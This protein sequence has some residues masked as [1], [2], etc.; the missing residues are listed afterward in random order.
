MARQALKSPKEA[1][2]V[3]KHSFPSI[4]QQ[5]SSPPANWNQSGPCTPISPTHRV[6][7]KGLLF[8]T[9]RSCGVGAATALRNRW[10]RSAHRRLPHRLWNDRFVY[11][12]V[13]N[14]ARR[15]KARRVTGTC[16][17]SPR[18]K[19][20]YRCGNR[21][22]QVRTAALWPRQPAS[23]DPDKPPLLSPSAGRGGPGRPPRGRGRRAGAGR[24]R[25][26]GRGRDRDRPPQAS[27][28]ESR[29]RC[30][31]PPRR[32]GGTGAGRGGPQLPSAPGR[33]RC[34]F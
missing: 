16:G 27:P 2:S 26:R 29:A 24:G 18:C 1:A 9:S 30:P 21:G 25:G 7:L 17:L 3:Y 15:R 22:R 12:H 5:L 20:C 19:S 4:M 32:P 11:S 33:R 13:L 8:G 23:A 10:R 31:G 34:P 14:W 28:G 6:T